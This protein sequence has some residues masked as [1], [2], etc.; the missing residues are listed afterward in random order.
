MKT[1][2]LKKANQIIQDTNVFQV[3][4][5]DEQGFPCQVALTPLPINRSGNSVLFYTSGK[6]TIIRNMTRSS[7]ASIFCF[8]EADY[9]SVSLKGTLRIMQ[10]EPINDELQNALTTF[11]KTL[12]YED[13]V[14]LK[15]SA[16]TLKVRYNNAITTENLEKLQNLD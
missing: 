1:E 12:N 4:T 8:N 11:Q 16:M 7:N 3:A 14:I 6:T 9:S 15:F 13:P 5:I 10:S 2:A